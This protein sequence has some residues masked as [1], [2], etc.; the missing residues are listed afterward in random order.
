[1]NSTNRFIADSKN[2][3]FVV[4]PGAYPGH[5]ML[6]D[7]VDSSRTTVQIHEYELTHN[8]RYREITAVDAAKLIAAY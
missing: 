5:L 4:T 3:V 6:N 1:M 7:A 2:N 8:R